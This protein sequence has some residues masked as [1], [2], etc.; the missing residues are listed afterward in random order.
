MIPHVA[1]GGAF[2]EIM[3]NEAEQQEGAEKID[4]AAFVGIP[5]FIET[6]SGKPVC[7][8]RGSVDW[9]IRKYRVELIERGALIPRS[10]RLGSLVHR[11]LFPAIV[12]EILKRDAIQ[13]ARATP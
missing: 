2:G 13:R 8:T 6:G 5:E 12:A 10:G 3:D 4:L 7:E 1:S 11:E 9:H